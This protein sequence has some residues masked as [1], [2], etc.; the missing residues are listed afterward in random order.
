[1]R[2]S[3]VLQ[4]LLVAGAVALCSPEASAQTPYVVSHS[5][6]TFTSITGGQTYAP[7]QYPIAVWPAWD[8]GFATIPLPFDFT[9]YSTTYDTVYAYTNGFVAFEP[10]AANGPSVLGPPPTVPSQANPIHAFIGA[11]WDDL[12]GSAA[13]SEIRAETLGAAPNRMFVVQLSGLNAL[14]DPSSNL[15]VQFVFYE[16]SSQFDIVY[17]PTNGLAG[18]TTAIE[19]ETGTEGLNL[20]ASSPTCGAG[21]TCAPGTCNSAN[22]QP[23]GF[24]ITTAL[25]NDPELT[26]SV[27]AP[28][29][30]YPGTSFD[31]DVDLRN[32]GL[33]DA[34]TY[35][36]ELY[37]T[38]S[39]T[40]TAGGQL[41]GRFTQNGQT[42][43]TVVNATH[44]VGMPMGQPVGT[45]YV[46]V[47]VDVDDTVVEVIETNNVTFS[48]PIVTA[49][50][51]TGAVVVPATTG[52]GEMMDVDFTLENQGAPVTSPISVSFFLSA[53]QTLDGF[54]ENV[55]TELIT[56]PDGFLFD[57]VVTM[58]IPLTVQPSPP[59]YYLIA[60]IDDQD[61]VAEPDENDNEIASA[62]SILVDGPELEVTSFTGDEIGFR[63]LTYPVRFTIENS[64]GATARDFTACVVLSDNLLI[65][66]VTDTLLPLD[67][68]GSTT[69]QLVTLAPGEAREYVL[70]PTIPAATS[71][72]TYY[73][74]A[75]ADC[76]TVVNEAVET[77]NIKRLDDP[78]LVRDIAPDFVPLEVST[79]SAAASG[80][81][82]PVAVRFANLGNDAGATHLR[83]VISDNPGATLMDRSIY[84]SM[85]PTMLG[86]PE[87]TTTSVWATLP[88]DL[89]SGTYYVGAVLDPDDLVDEVYEDNN[90]ATVGPISVVG[91]DLAIVSPAP[92]PAVIGVAYARR[93]S[94]VGGS[95][96]YAWEIEWQN[97]AAPAGLSFD[98]ALGEIAGT[99]EPAAEGRH[100]FTIRV[101]SGNLLAERDYTLIVTP[102][103][104]GLEVV[105]SRLPP[106]LALEPYSVQL[107]AVGGTPPY[108]WQLGGGNPPPGISVSS[109]GELGGEPQIVGGYTFEV[110]V[111]DATGARATGVLALDVIDPSASVTITTADVPDGEVGSQYETSFSAAGG[112][113][114]YSWR[115]DGII[116]GLSFDADT[117][118]LTGTPTVAG[119]YP[120]VVEVRD[121]DGLLDRNAYV[122]AIL[123]EGALQITN[124]QSSETGLP[125]ARVGE[126]YLDP[127][128][129]PVRLRAVKPGG[130]LSGVVW[131]ILVGDLP[132][133]LALDTATGVISGVPE[134][135]G[136]FPFIVQVRD[137]AQDVARTS[138]VVFVEP[139][140]TSMGGG[141]DGEGGCGCT[142]AENGS[143]LSSLLILGGLAILALWRRRRLGFFFALALAV[144]TPEAARAQPVPYQVFEETAPYQQLG[145]GATQLPGLGD[146]TTT[147]VPLPFDFY[148][149]G[150]AYNTIYVNA[151]GL[152]FVQNAGSGHH[153]PAGS[154]PSSSSPNGYIAG[155]W[156]DWCADSTGCFGVTNPGIGV[157]YEIDPTP[158]SQKITIEY[159]ALRHFSDNAM[160]SNS[161][162]QI[163]LHEGL[164]SKIEF[165]Y[166]PQSIGTDFFGG[167][168]Q[169]QG[170]IGIE[171]TTGTEGMWLGPCQ[172]SPC[173]NQDVL[174][175][176]DTKITVIA[177]AGE[178]MTAAG[179]QVPPVGYPGLPF[180]SSAR[181]ISR[182]MNPL[183]PF[184]YAVYLIPAT[185]T[186][187]AG[188]TLVYES[189]P[190]TLA[191]YESRLV[192][193]DVEVPNDQP[194]GQYRVGILVDHL[195]DVDE[196]SETNN[197]A[198][199]GSTVRIA[200]RAPDFRVV[201][202]RPL[203]TDVRPGDTLDVAYTVENFG[204]EPGT[205]E[206]ESYLSANEAITISDVP[207]A[208]PLSFDTAPREVI[209]GTISASVPA[210]IATGTYYVGL[211]LDPNLQ[212]AELD[213][214]NNVG[215]SG[216]RVTVS[217]ADVQIVTDALPTATLGQGYSTRIRAAGGSGEFTFALVDGDLPQGMI[218][219]AD[220]AE[221]TGVPLEIGTFPIEI[222]ATS[223][224]A[225]GS[226]T[227]DF[228]VLDPAY[229][230]TIASRSLPDGTLG[231]D[232]AVRLVAVGGEAPYVWRMTEGAL[233]RGLLFAPDGTVFGAPSEGGF[234]SFAVEVRDNMSATAS[235]ALTLD[236][237]SPGNLTIISSDLPE[238]R[239]DEPYSQQLVSVGGVEPVTWRGV[240]VLPDGLTISADGVL[241]GIPEIAGDYRF[242]VEVTDARGNADTNELTLEVVATGRFAIATKELPIGE[243]G[244]EY[245]AIIKAEG[246][247]E[248][249]TWELIRGEGFLP[250]G[251][252]V[253]QSDG[254]AEGET[255]NDL[256][257]RGTLERE[258]IWAFTARVWDARGRF[259]ER[260]FAIVSREPEA[261]PMPGDGDEGGCGCTA[262]G[263]TGGG[264]LGLLLLPLG[265]VFRRGRRLL[266]ALLFC[267]L[268][269]AAAPASAQ[270]YVSTQ[271]GSAYQPLSGGTALT[272]P[273]NDD[274]IVNVPLPFS[275]TYYGQSYDTLTV[276]VNGAAVVSNACTAD[277]DCG[278]ASFGTCSA[279]RCEY[280]VPFTPHTLPGP[281]LPNRVLSPFW[282]DL[283]F[284]SGSSVMTETLGTAPN[285][286]F[287]IQ[288][289]N[290]GRYLGFNTPSTSRAN[291]QLR[292]D[293]ASGAVRFHYG[294]FTSAADDALWVDPF[295]IPSGGVIGIENDD[296]TEGLSP[297]ACSGS[298]GALDLQALQDQI[299]E[300]ALPN[301]PELLGT[302]VAPTGGDPGVPLDV[303]VTVQNIGTQPSG[304]F[305]VAVYFSTD[306]TIDA[307]DTLID[308]LSFS[309]VAAMSSAMMTASSTV[310][311]VAPGFYT[312]GAI[313]DS[314]NAVTETIESNNTAVATTSFLVGAD[315]AVTVDTPPPSGPTEAFTAGVH[316]VNNGSA[317][318]AVGVAVY[319]SEDQNLDAADYLVGTATV[320][321]PAQPTTDVGVPCVVPA[322]IV[323][324]DYYAIAEVDFAGAIQEAD[325]NNNYGVSP[326]LAE[327]TGADVVAAAVDAEGNFAFR[328]GM[329]Q[330]LATIRNTGGAATGDFFY[331]FHL[332]EN[333]LINSLTDPLLGELG[334]ISLDAGESI[335]VTHSLPVPAGL[336]AGPYYLGLIA[337]SQSAVTEEFESNNINRTQRQLEVRDPAED[338]TAA[339]IRVPST[340]AA[341]E[342]IVVARTIVNAGNAPGMVEY[343]VYLSDDATIDPAVDTP[344]GNG[345]LQLT[346]FEEDVGV[347]NVRIPP[348]IQAGR[349]YVGYVIDPNDVVA[350]LDETNNI[351][352]G[353][354]NFDVLAS[355]LVIIT[356]RLPVAVLNT[357]YE[358]LFTAAGGAGSYTWSV[359]G[360]ALPAGLTLDS[361]G[362]LSGSATEEG[363]FDLTVAVSDGALTA[364]RDF[365]LVASAQTLPLEIVTRSLVPCFVGREYHYPLTAFGGVAPYRWS[366][367]DSLPA[368]LSMDE[369]GLISG[370]P[371]M[372]DSNTLT[373]RVED[374]AGAFA[375]RPIAI[376]VVNNDDTV[377]MSDDVLPDGRIGEQYDT[378]LK[379]AQGTGSSPFTFGL[380]GGALP[381]GLILELD[382]VYGIPEEVGIFTFAIRVTDSRGDFDV[383]RYVVE[384]E[385]AEGVGFV[386]TDLPRGVV[387]EAYADEL[388]EPVALK[389]VSSGSAGSITFRVVGGQLPPGMSLAMDGAISGAPS[390]AGI[391]PFT[392][393]AQDDRAQMSVRAYGIV[394]TDP[395]EEP[396][397]VKKEEGGCGCTAARTEGGSAG[398]LLL[399][400]GAVF[401]LRKRRL[402]AFV[403]ILG[404]GA[405]SIASAQQYFTEM[406]SEPYMERTGGAPVAFSSTDEDEVTVSLPFT[407]RFYSTD[408]TSVT[409]G[410]NGYVTFAPQGPEYVN[411]P[412]PTSAP[413]NAMIAPWWDDLDN[414]AVS[415]HEE[416]T[417]PNRS[418][419][420]Q[421]DSAQ[422]WLDSAAGTVKF[423]VILHEGPSGLFELRW[424]PS[425]GIASPGSWDAT[426]GYENATGSAGEDVLGCG[427][428][429]SGTDF[430]GALDT[431]FRAQQ[432]GGPDAVARDITVPR[433]VYPGIPFEAVVRIQSLHMNPLG[434][435]VY[436]IH[437]LAQGETEVNNPILTSQPFTLTPYQ[438]FEEIAM[439]AV[440]LDQP[441][442]R[443]ELAL[444]VDANDDLAEPNETNNVI[445]SA[446]DFRLAARQP[447]FTVASV[448][449]AVQNAS[450]G[451]SLDVEVAVRNGGN[452][453]GASD[454]RL[455]LSRNE[456]IS[457]DDLVV[458]TA[459]ATLPLLTTSSVSVNVALPSDLSPGDYYLGVV[460]DPANAVSEL[461]EVNNTGASASPITVVGD[462]VNVVTA[463]LP[464]GYVD[465]PYSA[466]LTA[467]G[468]DGSYAWSLVNGTLPPGLTLLST[469]EISGVP[470]QRTGA[471]FTVEVTSGGETAQAD[472]TIDVDILDGGLT[473]VTREVLPGI[474]GAAYPPAE[475]GTPVEQQQH[476][477]A[478]GGDGDVM[479]NLKSVPPPGLELETD[480]YL[481]GVPLQEG[482]YDLEIEATDGTSTVERLIRITVAEPGRLTLIA[483]VLPDGQ[484]EDEYSYQLRVIG[485][486]PTSTVTFSTG[487]PLPPGLTLTPAGRLVGIPQKVGSWIFTVTA[488]EGP[489]VSQDTANF[490]LT[491]L[492]D[493]GFGVTPSSLPLGRVNEPYKAVIEARDGRP[494]FTWRVLGS[495]L[496]RGL[497]YEIT[498]DEREQLVFKG[499]PEVEAF[500]TVLVTVTDGDGR[501]ARQPMSLLIETPEEAPLPPPEEGCGCTS[502]PM[503]RSTEAWGLILL[504]L[505]GFVRRRR[506]LRR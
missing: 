216:T 409:V 24:T 62:T 429:C 355:E 300:F 175:L 67:G 317:Q 358:V 347:D 107:V 37:L 187:T 291:F 88:G 46:A 437:L 446:T 160:A 335:Q 28:P 360:G 403:L 252:V 371:T 108:E 147:A 27:T 238:A 118:A 77:N 457:T 225:S 369:R 152:L 466:F 6:G 296:G 96:G 167:P 133:G 494:P 66:L 489:G 382:R 359:M 311:T 278:G 115:L 348:T 201:S 370:V 149:Y 288:W 33:Q 59:N 248:P 17:G 3:N 298:C 500:V 101:T 205:L 260:P 97:G 204:N 112:A 117:A 228:Q 52:P 156:S 406:V 405:P 315:L 148:F 412:I 40:S 129:E 374:A 451:S 464:G 164:S 299:I 478:I 313:I 113:P 499:V 503:G 274:G 421:W 197:F 209:T 47:I 341:G 177:D 176:P 418:V 389:A 397:P 465:V 290:I 383:N 363:T 207:F 51:L 232:Y 13:T 70:Q 440:P 407:F 19:N 425:S 42:A 384:I 161:N 424:G 5:T 333:E 332:S 486:L 71:T 234:T 30:A 31:V 106:A 428:G 496:P 279:N 116:P 284:G 194:V 398:W 479:F 130:D 331:A 162:F 460:M 477:V 391:Y 368:G 293:E 114:P 265:L 422:R 449:P 273:S 165:Q 310:P 91:A 203:S 60:D 155:L 490:R 467:L 435:M 186:S 36:Y 217:S 419:V 170:R 330:V 404:F 65:S 488:V 132:P 140:E 57:G 353:D 68:M 416:G 83:L 282:T 131:T 210:G 381:P 414:V 316:V 441:N 213:E 268:L 308:S 411:D 38:S 453:D 450:P 157:F 75:V 312:V 251:F 139:A 145:A 482:E 297:P 119:D 168:T 104:I 343:D 136:S 366:L 72:G 417:A 430:D 44:T 93:F 120:I 272:F 56:L 202:I 222:E 262:T 98:G 497:S 354:D 306:A 336:A 4:A 54:D 436:R 127:M 275:F 337:D 15:D 400:L 294:P 236:I 94:A 259:D 408:Y 427:V 171:N 80:E 364:T 206:I 111:R 73:V 69:T 442:G 485:R 452:L 102:P 285:R 81:Q 473:I 345:T 178:D 166:G 183:G 386:T 218:F 55:H 258:G 10:P 235:V 105:S 137:D 321:V 470:M 211:I 320:A 153:F 95:A 462:A 230:L 190:I 16:G 135:E 292:I 388:G 76:G 103:T 377:R 125:A 399:L 1:M 323:P 387:G 469:G 250:P 339:E 261:M 329:L 401:F 192:S 474:V 426:S 289:T 286:E 141:D 324:G 326:D 269:L 501:F 123:E 415:V 253:E 255:E 220:S 390:S 438:A 256:V 121:S 295:N 43:S 199:S 249:Y 214:A 242:R 367:Q 163:V 394:V 445:L 185:G 11:A 85:T 12:E 247:N 458:H 376:R 99:P 413:P 276:G 372:P 281:G 7:V 443:Y 266:Q 126:E 349:Y 420:I 270:L 327:V 64:G 434:P 346:A 50:D 41:L 151:N 20:L 142:S 378:M 280:F 375:E 227:F 423:Q 150:Q 245:R 109:D 325:E 447:D 342:S 84:D 181:I 344:L 100:P 395:P 484:L 29:G 243:P 492:E 82:L 174:S 200:D 146:G 361:S 350:E 191:G 277:A 318:P 58:T 455:V 215:R 459:S 505:L 322:N 246:G 393:M 35:D 231:S 48:G 506:G 491:V 365:T 461:D 439:P 224:A 396:P 244:M 237:R 122:L 373:F 481:H 495:S 193:F 26:A 229:P 173:S 189:A 87:E 240:T 143:P 195:A 431:V 14:G 264:W 89:A 184:Q 219:D 305:D 86:P 307:T 487:G 504:G 356:D 379:V 159:R 314:G 212:V 233:P 158:G 271:Y 53:D 169:I 357:E 90:V 18:A 287:V 302:A 78:V 303:D 74:A 2:S 198:A 362:F 188:G 144:L 471:N 340:G 385:E 39:N 208:T 483:A 45:Y 49:P 476:I 241:T 134:Q 498:E 124:G 380:A 468:G 179:V 392:V 92:P 475:P 472:L 63:G 110:F 444:E 239:L 334:P 456:V 304:A 138:L 502:A 283:L 263:R 196:T 254:I 301:G 402:G 172:A 61:Q 480:G 34:G 128:G 338:F 448:V 454:W 25:P 79:T 8:E 32:L 319:L 432:D 351:V 328:G 154:N 23:S 433:V 257:V 410:T 309:S 182:H 352:A 223:G 221:L 9:F 267:G 22:W 180:P 463:N 226:K 21:C 493:A